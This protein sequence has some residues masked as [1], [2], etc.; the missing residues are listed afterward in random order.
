MLSF[1]NVS[2]PPNLCMRAAIRP[3]SGGCG[4][5]TLEESYYKETG[6]VGRVPHAFTRLEPSQTSVAKAGR[7][8]DQ[9]K[10]GKP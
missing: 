3:G 5:G 4:G 2:T 9:A 10:V 6:S 8:I 7:T 1:A